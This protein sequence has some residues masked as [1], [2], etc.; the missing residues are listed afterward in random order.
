MYAIYLFLITR[1]IILIIIPS[2]V[3]ASLR[4]SLQEQKKIQ[5]TYGR[6]IVSVY[7]R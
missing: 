5:N 3:Q 1:L 6:S 2:Y 4:F 7:L